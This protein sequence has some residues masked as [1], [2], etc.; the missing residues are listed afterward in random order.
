V[1]PWVSAVQAPTRRAEW[2]DVRR[3]GKV[4]SLGSGEAAAQDSLGRSPRTYSGT[5]CPKFAF[6]ACG[7]VNL[8]LKPSRMS[9]LVLVVGLVSSLLTYATFAAG[10]PTMVSTTIADRF[11]FPVGAPNADGY[12]KS[13]GF[14]IRG[15]LGEDWVSAAGPGAIYRAPVTAI[16]NGVVALARD[17]KRSWGN[18]IVIRHAYYEGGRLTYADSLYAHLDKIFVAEGQPVS[19]GQEIGLVGNAHGLYHPHLHFEVHRNLGIGVVHMA[20]TRSMANYEDP[21]TFVMQH[22]VLRTAREK[23]VVD[24]NTYTMPT[25]AGIPAKPFYARNAVSRLA[26]TGTGTQ[27]QSFFQTFFGHR[28]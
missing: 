24:L 4:I 3:G 10:D 28:D 2:R 18:V 21:T 19:R 6:L 13:R 16:G 23:T 25:F 20:S 15:H 11:D 7:Q 9:R 26:S 8:R 1:W 14:N 27:R 5:F 22:R 12:Q 17:F